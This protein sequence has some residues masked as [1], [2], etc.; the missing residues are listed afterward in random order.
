LAARPV[1]GSFTIK[2]TVPTI[3]TP[4]VTSTTS[5]TTI[6]WNVYDIDGIGNV[7]L[8]IDGKAVTGVSQSGSGTSATFTYTGYVAAGSHNYVI[9]VTDSQKMSAKRSGSFVAA[10]ASTMAGSLKSATT[11]AS[12]K[13]EWLIDYAGASDAVDEDSVDAVFAG[14]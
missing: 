5:A 12:A 13:A 11:V 6:A 7:A 10:A 2:A 4:V 9:T 14:Y 1:S 3:S 8:T